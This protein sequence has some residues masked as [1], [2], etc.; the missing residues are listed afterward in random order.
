MNTMTAAPVAVTVFAL[1]VSAL[2]TGLV[3]A[4]VARHM[5]DHPNERSSHSS[6]VPRGGGLAVVA[7]VLGV[8]AWSGWRGA[9]APN[10]AIALMGGG[11]SVAFV[12]WL[13]DRS[14]LSS[15]LRLGVH[16]LAA[17][18]TVAWLG[19][20]PA[21]T[22]GESTLAFGAVGSIL[23]ALA[24][25][26]ST[27]LFN[28]MDGIDGIAGMEALSVGLFGGLLLLAR[29]APGLGGVALATA[30]AAL[31]FLCWN[32]SPAR[33]FMGDVGSGFLGYLLAGLALASENAQALPALVWLILASAFVLDATVTL[34]RRV[35]RG[36]WRDA[37]RTHAYQRAVQGGLSHAQVAALVGLINAV[38]GIIAI[39]VTARPAG[40]LG[41]VAAALV[42]VGAIYA[43]VGRSVPFPDLPRRSVRSSRD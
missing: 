39:V 33:I 24:V 1:T 41:G 8:I 43:L 5:L 6:A 10:V 26:W 30:G 36:Y 21:L 23:A 4:T 16:T 17:V 31:G 32:W 7:V 3:R 42:L 28:F 18:W 29:G 20:F 38:L 25:V 22:L 37:H 19:G 34:L 2:L 12:G 14:S 27:N 15:T 35:R 11:S 9:I 40:V 13:D